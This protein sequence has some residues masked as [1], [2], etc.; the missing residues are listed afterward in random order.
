[1]A[2]R[3]ERSEFSRN[4]NVDQCVADSFRDDIKRS[5]EIRDAYTI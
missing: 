1:M 5:G 3:A 4:A 2:V